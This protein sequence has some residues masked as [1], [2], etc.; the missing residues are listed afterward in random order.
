MTPIGHVA[1][2]YLAARGLDA[3][4]AAAVGAGL[5]PD[6]VDKLVMLTGRAASGRLFS[7]C[8]V[9]F[10]GSVLAVWI[11]FGDALA[12]AWFAGYATHLVLDAD[13]RL[14]WFYLL[15]P[16]DR[17]ATIWRLDKNVDKMI[18]VEAAAL[19]FAALVFG[20]G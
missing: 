18:C 15:F 8:L 2:A 20:G 13:Y 6:V 16:H 9:T 11:V 4:A 14:P 5:F 10:I 12:L 19:F 17:P 1:V 7:H 3:P